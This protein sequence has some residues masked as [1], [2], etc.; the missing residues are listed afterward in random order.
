M[1]NINYNIIMYAYSRSR[2]TTITRLCAQTQQLSY[3]C[4]WFHRSKSRGTRVLIFN[5][6]WPE[7]L[8]GRYFGGLL[9]ICHLAEF[10]FA[11]EPVLAIMIFIAKWLIERSEI[12]TLP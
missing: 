8:A 2:V 5:T 1:N 10:T 9:K 11:V 7:I 6:V 4:V 12:L 3:I